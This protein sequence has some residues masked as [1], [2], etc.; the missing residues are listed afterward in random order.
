M[1]IFTCAVHTWR[2]SDGRVA[3][4]VHS[5]R[6]H[7]QA[8][9]QSDGADLVVVRVMVQADAHADAHAHVHGVRIALGQ[10]GHDVGRVINFDGQVGARSSKS[11]ASISS[12]LF[13]PLLFA[14]LLFSRRR[15][16]DTRTAHRHTHT[17]E[18]HTTGDD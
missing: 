9:D 3:E 4:R 15:C 12:L 17:H 10:I 18:Q 2:E 8:A 6:R 14:S 16:H 1:G 5:R 11:R 13:S 7:G